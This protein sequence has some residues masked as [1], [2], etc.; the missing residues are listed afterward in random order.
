MQCTCCIDVNTFF[1]MILNALLFNGGCIR[2]LTLIVF[3]NRRTCVI[4]VR[5][6]AGNSIIIQ[7]PT[8]LSETLTWRTKLKVIQPVNPVVIHKPFIN[9][10]ITL[11]A[12]TFV[13]CHPKGIF[14]L[15]FSAR[16][17]TPV[18]MRVSGTIKAQ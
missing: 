14:T 8:R 10:K 3:S 6:L 16:L 9:H 2:Q 17:S 11:G 18:E 5:L 15:P 12:S 7:T 1:F 13:A 4:H